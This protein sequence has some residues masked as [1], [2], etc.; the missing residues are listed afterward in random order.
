MKLKTT[1]LAASLLVLPLSGF[2]SFS[3]ALLNQHSKLGEWKQTEL[4]ESMKPQLYQLLVDKLR[5]DQTERT[6]ELL[7]QMIHNQ[8]TIIK[9][10]KQKG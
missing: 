10:L 3:H 8:E 1:L 2:A 4:V 9:L 6:H 5:Y 7:E